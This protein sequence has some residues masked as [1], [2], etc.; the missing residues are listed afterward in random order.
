MGSQRIGWFADELV[1][2]SLTAQCRTVKLLIDEILCSMRVLVGFVMPIASVGQSARYHATRT[3]EHFPLETHLEARRGD[4][5]RPCDGFFLSF[6]S[7][8]ELGRIYV[9]LE[10]LSCFG[11]AKMVDWHELYKIIL[12]GF[13]TR[14]LMERRTFWLNGRS[15]SPLHPLLFAGWTSNPR[16]NRPKNYYP[17]FTTFSERT[18]QTFQTEWDDG[19]QHFVIFP[20]IP[21]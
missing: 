4:F 17:R 3:R 19:I 15:H 13:R 21:A 12:S 2:G 8:L 5:S 20:T 14:G 1:G 10:P 16:L 6:D 18:T 7:W 11:R 9:C